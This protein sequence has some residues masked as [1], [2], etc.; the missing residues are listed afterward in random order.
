MTEERPPPMYTVGPSRPR[1]APPPRLSTPA[2]NLTR[3]G[4]QC[5]YPTSFQYAALSWGIPLP[6]ASGSILESSRPTASDVP[7]MTQKLAVMKNVR[8]RSMKA[9]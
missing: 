2:M 4:R 1:L 9:R 6:A 5:T 8:E 7:M 3:T